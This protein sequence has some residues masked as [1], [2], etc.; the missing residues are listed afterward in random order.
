LSS[1]FTE[2]SAAKVVSDCK[3]RTSTSATRQ[4]QFPTTRQKFSIHF[5]PCRHIS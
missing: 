4:P 2:V 5:E 1:L 3:S